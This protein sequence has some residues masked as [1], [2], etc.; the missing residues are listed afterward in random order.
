MGAQGEEAGVSGAGASEV[1]VAGVGV[2]GGP[3]LG[4]CD[5]RETLWRFHPGLRSETWGTQLFAG[6]IG[7]GGGATHRS[8]FR[9]RRL[10]RRGIPC[11]AG[12]W[13][14]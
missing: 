10:V 1:D 12:V 14:W 2:P 4:I 5:F 3:G 8:W 13:G 11:R 6:L 9:F 7:A